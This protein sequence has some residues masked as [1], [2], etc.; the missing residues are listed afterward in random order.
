MKT[1]PLFGKGGICLLLLFAQLSL[2]A[3]CPDGDLSFRNQAEVDQFKNDFPNCKNFQEDIF[4]DFTD[5]VTN[6]AGLSG[7]ESIQ[8]QLFLRG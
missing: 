3:Q 6:L 8:G 5:D 1:S 7:I 4:F 2:V